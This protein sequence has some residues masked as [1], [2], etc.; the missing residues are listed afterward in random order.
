MKMRNPED[1]ATH[2]REFWD[3]RYQNFSLSESGWMGAGERYNAYL[4]ACKRQAL[5]RDCESNPRN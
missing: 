5:L 2:A 3:K 4:Y 1:A